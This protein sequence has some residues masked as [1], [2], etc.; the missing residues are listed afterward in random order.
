M[1]GHVVKR[2]SKYSYIIDLGRD[3]V[4]KKRKQKRVSGF[5]SEKKAR[6][7]MIDM[8]AEIN[9]G[10]YVEPTNKNL[11]EYLDEWLKHKEKRVAY[12]TYLHY[13]GFVRNH[14]KPAIGNVKTHELKPMQLQLFY[15]GLLD[16]GVLSA[17]SIH[18]IHRIISNALNLGVRMGEVQR[19]I[20]SA[21]DP[22][23]V[24]KKELNYWDVEDVNKYVEVARSHKHFIAFY[25]AIF[26]GMRQGE[27]LGLKWDALDFDNKTI[28]VH[29]AIKR[30]EGGHVLDDLKNDPSYR[31]IS[32]SESLMF[33]LK[34]H[35]TR[36]KEEKLKLGEDYDDQGFVVAT[37]VGSFVLPTN[38]GRAFRIMLKKTKVKQIR[39]HDMR[40]THASLLFSQN[41]HPKIVQ[42]RLGHSSI[43][44]TLDTYSHMLPNM[45]EAAAA[46]L[47]EMFADKNI[48]NENKNAL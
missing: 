28:H 41:I 36:Q 16:A 2:G 34:K 6:K 42:E 44:I 37:A 23:T 13:E 15:D 33:E 26:T 7:S 31:S 46:K 47:D 8:I 35:K 27:V 4:T 12:G 24:K 39:F 22:V 32:M 3:P 48:E 30:K 10:G 1:R 40:H 25:L 20:A 9:K 5:T 14:I 19:N 29:R 38:I 11:G 45:Q 17:R 21:V 18:H 43:Q